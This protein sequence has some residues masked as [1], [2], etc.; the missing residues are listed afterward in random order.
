MSMIRNI[1]SNARHFALT[2]V[3]GAS[4]A[5]AGCGGGG[6]GDE[7]ARQPRR[8]GRP[9]PEP[10]VVETEFTIPSTPE[11]DGVV[12]GDNLTVTSR[13]DLEPS[14]GDFEFIPTVTN[15]A[16]RAIGYYSF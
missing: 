10:P 3:V 12:F 7:P 6:G 16:A 4:I 2:A 11:L 13:N 5:F 15:G 9:S 8:P 1:L 14:V